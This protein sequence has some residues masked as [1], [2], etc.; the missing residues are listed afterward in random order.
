MR[1]LRCVLD[2]F[3]CGQE[4]ARIWLHHP[5][6]PLGNIPPIQLMDTDA[7][8]IEIEDVLGRIRHGIFS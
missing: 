4:G 6:R 7:G 5:C 2:T 8:L 3:G 1:L